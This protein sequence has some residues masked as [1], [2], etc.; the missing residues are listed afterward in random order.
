MDVA[1]YAGAPSPTATLLLLLL[2]NQLGKWFAEEMR[3]LWNAVFVPL[4]PVADD[5]A[6]TVAA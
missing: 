4:G 6:E 1:N 2:H 5:A 3:A